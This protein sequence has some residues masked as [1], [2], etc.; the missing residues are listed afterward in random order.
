MPAL[1]YLLDTNILSAVIKQP[2][3]N[4]A[5]KVAAQRPDTLCTS[6]IVAGELRYGTIKKGSKRLTAR[7]NQVLESI[8][9]LPLEYGVHEHYGK[10]RVALEKAGQPIGHNDLLIAAHAR[11]QGLILVS[12][13]VGEFSRIEGLQ[14]EN[15]LRPTD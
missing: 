13:N 3:G 6:I 4:L 8:P 14:L 1:R 2:Q 5:E 9:V 11:S 15:W 7:V 10:I 12:D